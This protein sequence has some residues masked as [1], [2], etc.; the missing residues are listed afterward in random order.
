MGCVSPVVDGNVQLSV[1]N[2]F[3]SASQQHERFLFV[4][5]PGKG[6]FFSS[7]TSS[8]ILNE[9]A[10]AGIRQTVIDKLGTRLNED[11]AM[12]WSDIQ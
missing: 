6:L 4:P 1:G 10:Y 11:A 5:F 3:F 12:I 8:M 2:F 9:V 7:L